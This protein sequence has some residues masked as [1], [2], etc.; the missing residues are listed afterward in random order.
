MIYSLSGKK[1]DLVLP[2][3]PSA[4]RY[5][6]SFRGRMIVSKE[7]KDYIKLVNS[8]YPE[9]GES[10]VYRTEEMLHGSIAAEFNFYPPDRRKRDLDNLLKI[11]IDSMMKTGLFKDDSQIDELYVRRREVV[12]DGCLEVS[13]FEIRD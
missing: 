9:F 6:R 7:A 3:P 12:K 5:W 2:W 8:L 10:T 1:I 11:S 4:N 13:I